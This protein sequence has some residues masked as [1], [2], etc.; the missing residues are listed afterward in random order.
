MID[1]A[2]LS[3]VAPN[4]ALPLRP[5]GHKAGQFRAGFLKKLDK[6]LKKMGENPW[7]VPRYSIYSIDTKDTRRTHSLAKALT[8]PLISGDILP[9][10]SWIFDMMLLKQGY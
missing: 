8:A 9:L 3:W 1:L 4:G 2:R 10:I 7:K 5:L 6:K